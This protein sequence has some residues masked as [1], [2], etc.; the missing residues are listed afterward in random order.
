VLLLRQAEVDDL[1]AERRQ[2]DVAGLQVAVHDAL[3]MGRVQRVAHVGHVA[4]RV[5]PRH[6]A[7]EW[8][9]I[10]ELHHEIA[11]A[12]ERPDVVE[13][14]DMRVIEGRDGPGLALEAL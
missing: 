1:H 2:Q 7:A 9:P 10:D 3:A 12:F 14:A 4:N 8:F 13:R 5:L 11:G 6:R